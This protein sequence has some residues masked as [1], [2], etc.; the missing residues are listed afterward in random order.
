MLGSS[1]SKR[2]SSDS[3]VDS[4]GTLALKSYQPLDCALRV[5]QFAGAFHGIKFSVG[6]FLSRR[7]K[8]AAM[9]FRV[10]WEID[11]DADNPTAAA[12][13]ARALQLKINTSATVF[14]IWEPAAGK[15]HRIDVEADTERLEH[16]ELGAFRAALRLLQCDRDVRPSIREVAMTMLIFLDRE[17]M[18]FRR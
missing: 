17:D 7:C 11:I 6:V 9:E 16:A 4:F 10:I 3:Y 15:R 18:M 14:D 13:E 2:C 12:Q 1:A 8:A 5:C